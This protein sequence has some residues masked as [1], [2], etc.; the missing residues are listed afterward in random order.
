MSRPCVFNQCD[1]W[2]FPAYRWYAAF[3]QHAT[4]DTHAV[5]CAIGQ[6]YAVFA[7]TSPRTKL[8]NWNDVRLL[9][10]CAE[11]GGFAGAAD[12]LGIDQKTIARRIGQL[13]DII[14]RKL[15]SRQKTGSTLTPAGRALLERATA[16][17]AAARD[18]EMAMSGLS[19]QLPVVT[20]AAPEGLLTYLLIPLLLGQGDA[21]L[22]LDRGLL[23]AVPSNLTFVTPPDGGD[24]NLLLL[25]RDE[26]VPR[27]PAETAR[28]IGRLRMKP[29][30]A[31]DVFACAAPPGSFA[32]LAGLPLVDI[33]L[34]RSVSSLDP[35][36]RL[37]A[38]KTGGG[39]IVA[40]NTTGLYR[41]VAAGA[42]IGLAPDFTPLC[43]P[44]LTVLEMPQPDLSIELWLTAH[45]DVLSDGSIQQ[46]F[47]DLARV[48]AASPW[49]QE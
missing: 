23:R 19:E 13:E 27:P 39:L 29:V 8:H 43:D 5:W 17:D 11:N 38:A 49:F 20:L 21:A 36:N 15:F 2:L 37:V 35:W 6:Q 47:N 32:A 4:P 10:A 7:V 48:F 41:A 30:A 33:T 42:G 12:A 46:L 24:I 3:Q 16:M 22:P 45:P 26:P 31:A 25:G 9:I 1:V 40:P 44:R 18:L 14:G 28:R 34:Y